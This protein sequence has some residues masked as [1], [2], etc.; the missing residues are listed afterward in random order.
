MQIRGQGAGLH[1]YSAAEGGEPVGAWGAPGVVFRL[2]INPQAT[3]RKHVPVWM[4]R[5]IQ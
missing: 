2:C 4:L 1:I 5:V 3:A